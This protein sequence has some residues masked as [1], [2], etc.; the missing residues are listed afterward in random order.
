MTDTE[1]YDAFED[2]SD[3][4]ERARLAQ[5]CH[6]RACAFADPVEPAGVRNR[7]RAEHHCVDQR[8]NCRGSADSQ[9]QR[10]YRCSGKNRRH[11]ELSHGIAKIAG[12]VLH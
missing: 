3:P 2:A 10:Q 6:E 5:A 1:L 9:G 12:K 8:K 11:P 4:R 7:Q